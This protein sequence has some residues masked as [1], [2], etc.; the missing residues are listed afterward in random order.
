MA[1]K[2]PDQDAGEALRRFKS[3][4]KAGTLGNF[5]IISGEEAFLRSHYVDLITKKIADGPAGEF[6]CHRFSADDCT[7][8]A[9]ADA[10]DAMPMMAERTLV[11]VDDVDLF[12]QPE[13]AREPVT[14]QDFFTLGLSGRPDSAAKRAALLQALSLPAHMSANAL[15]QAVNVLFSREEFLARFVEP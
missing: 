1:R 12:K 15:L 13:G 7:P 3:D 8:Q 4:L 9:L 5:Y 2:A 14:K 11:R 6:N 10:I